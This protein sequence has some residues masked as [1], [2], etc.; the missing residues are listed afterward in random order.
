MSAMTRHLTL[1]RNVLFVLCL[2]PALWLVWGFF[3]HRLGANPFEV[4]TR[5][6]GLW[7]LRL[8]LLT[9]LVR[10][11]AEQLGQPG[12]LRLRRMLGL[13][14]FFYAGLHMLTYLWFD[15]FFDWGEIGLDIAKRPYI[16]IGMLAF[17]LLIPLAATSTR[18]MMRRLGRRW[19]S[20][21]RLVYLIAPMGVV[22][23]LLLVKADILE[24]LIYA[25]LLGLLLGYRGWRSRALHLARAPA[26][27]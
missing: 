11:L 9:L 10:P 6:T 12:L 3:Q 19:Q 27:R 1:I 25:G 2:V 16:T 5:D 15:Q 21:H 23:F 13:Y 24:P 7:T 18:A 22:H 4:L 20:L 17:V 14:S 26:G 8:L